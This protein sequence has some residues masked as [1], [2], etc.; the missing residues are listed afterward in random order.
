MSGKIALAIM[1][2]IILSFSL[3]VYTQSII[4]TKSNTE[5]NFYYKNF[6]NSKS[7]ILLIGSSYVGMLKATLIESN[8]HKNNLDVEVFNLAIPGDKPEDRITELEDILKL[9]PKIV[10]YGI[11]FRAFSSEYFI[12]NEKIL[13]DPKAATDDFFHSLNLDFLKN[14][15]FNTLSLLRDQTNI[16][17]QD[18]KQ[19]NTPFFDYTLPMYK[20]NPSLITDKHIADG[21][22]RQIPNMEKNVQYHSTIKLISTLQQNNV[23]L[24]FFITPHNYSTI[25]SLTETDKENFYK[26]ISNIESNQ[27]I[28]V[29]SL[30]E[31]YSEMNVWTSPDHVTISK[32]GYIFNDDIS[33]LILEEMGK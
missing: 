25:N 14:P 33:N 23:K 20:T 6:D 19:Y 4:Y 8:L 27:K 29:F 12:D 21:W 2:A 16:K 32:D 15:K 24:I 9:E 18:L 1:I 28:Q 31:N 11:G 3:F 10:V 13:P 30:L 17:T 26:I 22:I 5:N 7:K